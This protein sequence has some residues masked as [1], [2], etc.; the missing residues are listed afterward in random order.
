MTK[1]GEEDLDLLTEPGFRAPVQ[2]LRRR[3]PV[4]IFLTA[5]LR[6]LLP[7]TCLL[8]VFALSRYAE[9]IPVT[10]FDRFPA[11]QAERN[12]SIWLTGSHFIV[13]LT[14][15]VIHLTNRAYGAAMAFAQTLIAWTILVSGTI[16]FPNRIVEFLP[17]WQ[18]LPEGKAFAFAVALFAGHLTAIAVFDLT[19]GPNW[20]K[21]PLNAGL[22]GS[23]LYVGLFHGMAPLTP[24]VTFSLAVAIDG[25]IN[26]LMALLLLL[27]YWML[28]PAIRPLPGYGGA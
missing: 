19:R 27:P 23:A 1:Y 28:R 22:F 10:L 15:F 17:W 7:V 11:D 2:G 3:S 18:A 16:Y 4:Q 6:L 24:E 21:A 26:F 25:T 13:P 12:L 8:G 9:G 20:W 5:V 14:F